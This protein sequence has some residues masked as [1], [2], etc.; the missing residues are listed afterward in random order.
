M[1]TQFSN[2]RRKILNIRQNMFV[3]HWNNLTSCRQ[4]KNCIRIDKKT[5][6]FLLN[7]SRTRLKKY[8]GT[9]TGHFGFNKHLT[10]LGKRLDS[11]CDQCGEHLET[12]E[13]FLCNCSPFIMA[14]RK[15][16]GSYTINYNLIRTLQPKDIL[17]YIASTGRF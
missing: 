4:A 16:L 15:H 2:I 3:W 9:T 12:A 5:S 8:V 17:N 6:K 13:H 14:R 7:I 11:S 10:T 1:R